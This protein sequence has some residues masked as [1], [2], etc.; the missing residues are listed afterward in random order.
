MCMPLAQANY[1]LLFLRCP[2]C[3]VGLGNLVE[4]PQLHFFPFW[5]SANGS[6]NLFSL[7]KWYLMKGHCVGLG[8]WKCLMCVW[9]IARLGK[10]AMLCCAHLLS[11]LRG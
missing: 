7:Q 6:Q 9:W 10:A 1:F 3:S 11:H 2:H 8:W 4:V 5:P